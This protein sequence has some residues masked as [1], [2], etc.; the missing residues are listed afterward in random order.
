M[1]F[2]LFSFLNPQKRKLITEEVKGFFQDPQLV[3]GRVKV[4]PQAATAS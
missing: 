4:K 2:I 1:G 3:G